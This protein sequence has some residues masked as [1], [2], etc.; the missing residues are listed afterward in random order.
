MV[1]LTKRSVDVIL[2]A[3]VPVGQSEL[4]A[5]D[6]DIPG[7]GMRV[8]AS[9]VASYLIQYRNKFGR[10]RRFTLGRCAVLTPEEARRKAKLLLASVLAGGDPADERAGFRNDLTI[11]ELCDVYLAEGCGS[12]KPG[13]LSMDRSRIERHVKPLLGHIKVG[14]L[15]RAAVE[16]FSLDVANGKSARDQKTASRGR[17]IVRGGKGV[18][19]RTLG[20]LGAIF[21]FAVNRGLRPDNP[22]RGVRKFA[23]GKKERFLLPAEYLRLRQAL[24]A[25]EDEGAN[26]SAVNAI[27]AL[28][29]T[30]CRKQ[31]ILRLTW[32]EIDKA[33]SCLRLLD[34]KT[35]AKVVPLGPGAVEFLEG[36]QRVKDCPWVFPRADAKG[37]LVG[38]QKIWGRVRVRASLP[39]VRIHDLRHSFASMGAATGEGLL[40]IGKILGHQHA[41]TTARYAHMADDPLKAAADRITRGILLAMEG[42]EDRAPPEASLAAD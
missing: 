13:T 34:S 23:D 42:G 22:I 16:R 9:G 6:A 7:F 11:A 27:R 28:V 41:A 39:D 19:T 38:L 31:E 40:M 30:G 1:K 12:K 17:S 14:A 33:N 32:V 24:D 37:P 36:L 4:Y 29:L 15:N 25:C 2:A 35:G 5:W 26:R 20:M 21:Q 3:G 18:A 10:S 8:K